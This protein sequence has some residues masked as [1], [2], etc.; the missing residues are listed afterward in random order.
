MNDQTNLPRPTV[1][2]PEVQ[3][4]ITKAV[5]AGS[6]LVTACDA[7]GISYT[8][9][10]HWQKR[11]EEGDAAAQRY[12]DFFESIKKASAIAEIKAIQTIKDMPLGWQA[13]AWFLERRFSRRWGKQE[14][15]AKN[16]TPAAGKPRITIADADD[17]GDSGGPIDPD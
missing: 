16:D 1:L 8:I 2:T 13:Q 14:R 11:W 17:T 12:A 6:Y 3:E 9:F 15:S 5:A 4:I 7:A 10:R